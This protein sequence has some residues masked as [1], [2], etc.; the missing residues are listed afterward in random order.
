MRRYLLRR[1]LQMGQLLLII[2]GLNFALIH[3]APGAP[4][5]LLAGESGD[6]AYY[7]A[8]RQRWGLDRSLGEQWLRYLAQVLR[9]EIGHSFQYQQPVVRVIA[10][11]LPPTLLLMGST[12]VVS[13]G[14]GLWLSVQASLRAGTA[15]DQTIV[16]CTLLGAVRPTFWVGQLL[17]IIF[18]AG[19]GLFPIQGM[20]SPRADHTG[21][22]YVLDVAH[23]L[24]L[25]AL[26]LTVWQLA[27]I[28]H[29]TRTGMR[30]AF[31][32]VYPDGARQGPTTTGYRVPA[33][34]A[35][36]RPA[37]HHG[38][39]PA[40]GDPAGG[41]DPHGDR[42]RLARVGSLALRCDPGPGLSHAHG[43]GAGHRRHGHG[44]HPGDRPALCAGR[45]P[46]SL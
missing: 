25:P 41:G 26:T 38:G 9:G 12:L 21:L 42:V 18:A 34:A 44:R 10:S 1:V 43:H 5:F 45:S 6:E 30:D 35:Q 37:P 22:R 20:L 7:A 24:V 31:R 23:H 14:L 40:D 39:R 8:M 4:I 17:V 36:C 3:L 2:L 32:E 33:C 19:L 16:T 13:T 27:L 28:V 11:R 15:V 46:H 29:V